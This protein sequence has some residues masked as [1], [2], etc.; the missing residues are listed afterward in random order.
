MDGKMA[1]LVALAKRQPMTTLSVGDMA[2]LGRRWYALDRVPGYRDGALAGP[3]PPSRQT[4][5]AM[6]GV[7]WDL[8]NDST[9]LRGWD[10]VERDL[11]GR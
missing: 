11:A 9:W 4:G 3:V 5:L 6:E 10:D 1:G 8:P 2:D 7:Y